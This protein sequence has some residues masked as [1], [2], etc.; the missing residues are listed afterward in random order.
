MKLYVVS[1]SALYGEGGA[2][3]NRTVANYTQQGGE[4]RALVRP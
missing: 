4:S 1:V 3:L 2:G